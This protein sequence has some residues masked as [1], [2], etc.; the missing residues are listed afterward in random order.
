M[1]R[2]FLLRLII[3]VQVVLVH[4]LRLILPYI[5]MVGLMI[6]SELSH[7]LERQIQH[8]HLA[9]SVVVTTFLNFGKMMMGLEYGATLKCGI[10]NKL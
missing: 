10:A 5:E 3:K 9:M 8:L 1:A 4:Q 2:I 7:I 6:I